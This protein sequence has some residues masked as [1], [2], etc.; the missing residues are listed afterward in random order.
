MIQV[1]HKYIQLN[2]SSK[3]FMHQRLRVILFNLK[4]NKTTKQ[5]KIETLEF[6]QNWLSVHLGV[7]WR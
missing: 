1:Q 3:H 2:A 5:L 6:V 7:N 4:T